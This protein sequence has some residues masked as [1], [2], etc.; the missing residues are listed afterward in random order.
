MALINF[1][2]STSEEQKFFNI[3]NGCELDSC[4]KMM[5]AKVS[6]TVSRTEI[7]VKEK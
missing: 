1:T 6:L 2:L 3:K 5:N 7:L 4:A